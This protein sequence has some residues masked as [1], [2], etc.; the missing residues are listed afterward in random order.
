MESS[1]CFRI[2]TPGVIHETIDE[3]VV[4]IEFE[5]GNY[6]SLDKAGAAIWGFIAG[7]ATVG[8]IVEGIVIGTRAAAKI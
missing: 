3:E 4:I 6:Y 1:M 5:S 8:G 2:N 7:G